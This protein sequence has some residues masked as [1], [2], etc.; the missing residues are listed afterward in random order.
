MQVI[1]AN[2]TLVFA[3]EA[4]DYTDACF[5]DSYRLSAAAMGERYQKRDVNKMLGGKSIGEHFDPFSELLAL[6]TCRS[7]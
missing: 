6:V 1:R 4:T 2:D 7:C 5:K 3:S